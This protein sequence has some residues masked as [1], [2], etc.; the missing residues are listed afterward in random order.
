MK[1]LKQF[2]IHNQIMISYH[3]D[4]KMTTKLFSIFHYATLKEH[5]LKQRLSTLY[6]SQQNEVAKHGNFRIIKI[7]SRM[8]HVQFL[9]L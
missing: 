2:K 7:V 5:E 3:F 1:S 6:I 4:S 9:K 8:I